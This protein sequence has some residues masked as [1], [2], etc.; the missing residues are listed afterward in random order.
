MSPDEGSSP[1]TTY[2]GLR[3]NRFSLKCMKPAPVTRMAGATGVHGERLHV[4]LNAPVAP[5][6]TSPRA[7]AFKLTF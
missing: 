2:T 4:D 6:G 5:I 1:S 3:K 7:P